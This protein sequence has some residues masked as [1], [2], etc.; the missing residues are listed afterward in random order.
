M[1][2]I[3]LTFPVT[4]GLIYSIGSALFPSPTFDIVSLVEADLT[5]FTSRV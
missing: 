5:V 1:E 2:Y 3:S 4:L